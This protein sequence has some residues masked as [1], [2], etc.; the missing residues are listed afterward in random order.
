MHRSRTISAAVVVA[1][2]ALTLS[3]LPAQAASLPPSAVGDAYSVM[4][5]TIAAN[6]I[7]KG[8]QTVSNFGVANSSQGTPDPPWLCDL[9]GENEVEGKGGEYTIASE[10]LNVAGKNVTNVEQEIH[11]YANEKKAKK[12]Y[13]GI[14]K[15]IKNCEGQ[16]TPAADDTDDS[17]LNIT[18][19]LT[20]GAKKAKDGDP[21]LW[22]SSVTVV[23]DSIT[24]FVDHEYL[25]VRLLGRYIQIFQV[26][27]EGNNAPAI[28]K[29][30]IAAA[31]RLQ[32]SLGDAWRA[33]FS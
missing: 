32:D 10:V 4:L 19:T 5:N 2:S 28:T 13:D 25:T 22:V 21:F 27:S 7:S 3:A 29:K 20:N 33:K 8:K 31:D 30:Q 9:S 12:A 26:E 11:W 15:V 1:V 14:V 23:G 16:H 24:N 6:L 17:P 18:T